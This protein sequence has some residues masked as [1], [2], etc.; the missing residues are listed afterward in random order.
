[1]RLYPSGKPYGHTRRGALK[2]GWLSP[3]PGNGRGHFSPSPDP[4]RLRLPA[5]FYP[6]RCPLAFRALSRPSLVSV[7]CYASP[8]RLPPRFPVGTATA[9]GSAVMSRRPTSDGSPPTAGAT[10]E[11]RRQTGKHKNISWGR[12]GVARSPDP[13]GDLLSLCLGFANV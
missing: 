10:R 6:T 4:F 13:S 12:S 9:V 11:A 5:R 1:M 8:C 2:A 7:S 3:S